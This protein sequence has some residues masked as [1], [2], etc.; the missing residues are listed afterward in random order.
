MPYKLSTYYRGDNMEKRIIPNT[1][2]RYYATEDGHIYDAKLNKYVSENKS[3]RGWLKCHVWYNKKR[4]TIGVHRLIAYAF[5]GISDLTVNHINGDKTDNSIQNLEYMSLQDQNWHRSRV[6]HTGNQK[7]IICIEQNKIYSSAVEFCEAMGFNPN[8]THI[9]N[10][11][12]HQYGFKTYKG[13]HFEYVD[14]YKRE[15]DIEKI[16]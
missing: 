9:S 11:C 15:E 3:K 14:N 4:I 2:N 1:D 6:L 10:V 13:F 5:L 16:S 7:P 8:N 12:K